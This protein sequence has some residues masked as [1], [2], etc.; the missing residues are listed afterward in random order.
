MELFLYSDTSHANQTK[1]FSYIVNIS[2][3]PKKTDE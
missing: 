3:N 1:K 2:K